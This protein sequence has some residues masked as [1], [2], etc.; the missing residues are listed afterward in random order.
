MKSFYKI[1]NIMKWFEGPK[2]GF[3]GGLSPQNRAYVYYVV[4]LTKTKNQVSVS[5]KN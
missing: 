3:G 5:K 1:R 4:N 2:I